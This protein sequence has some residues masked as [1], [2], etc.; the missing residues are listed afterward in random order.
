MP[1]TWWLTRTGRW[2]KRR[3]LD[4]LFCI[5]GYCVYGDAITVSQPGNFRKRALWGS[6]VEM[7]SWS[8]I[9]WV[10]DNLEYAGK[11][12]HWAFGSCVWRLGVEIKTWK[13]RIDDG[14]YYR[15]RWDCPER[16][17]RL[18]EREVGW[19]ESQYLSVT[20]RRKAKWK[21]LEKKV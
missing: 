14:W 8:L 17:C 7:I 19:K 4:K 16:D 20:G 21:G 1:G 3:L 9:S 18:G 2:N 5:L 11:M 6:R 13:Y 12:A 10:W 15:N